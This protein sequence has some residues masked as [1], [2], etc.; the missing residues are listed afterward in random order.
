M[1]AAK[2]S[3]PLVLGVGAGA[4]ALWWHTRNGDAAPRALPF[5]FARPL[6]PSVRAIVSSG[7]ARP[8]RRG[9]HG[10][11]DIPIPV[12]T[13]VL[14]ID[15]GLIVRVQDD[16]HGD[17]GVWVGV[18]HPCGVVSRYLHLSHALARPGAQ[19]ARGELLGKSGNTGD[20]AGPHL[21]LDLRAQREQLDVV[22][23]AVG[24][25]RSGWGAPL[26]PYGYSIP[27]EPWIPVDGYLDRVR[28]DAA[29]MTIPLYAE[30]H[31]E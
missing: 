17:A 29:R 8:R 26:R 18:A 21:H 15:D 10:A 24:R 7:W 30:V 9:L 13:P 6:P 14:A 3:A 23:H 28:A 4:L 1:S 31:H 27:G 20:S 22:A 2:A 16:A 19:V 12:G 25:P 11:L 5:D